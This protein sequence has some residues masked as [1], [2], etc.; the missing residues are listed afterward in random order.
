MSTENSG[1]GDKKIP[2]AVTLYLY[3]VTFFRRL[4]G[5]VVGGTIG[6]VLGV[7]YF[8]T[9]LTCLTALAA[10]LGIFLYNCLSAEPLWY[11]FVLCSAAS[12]AALIAWVGTLIVGKSLGVPAKDSCDS[13]YCKGR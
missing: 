2:Q 4:I 13:D 12:T 3:E 9:G 5:T 10:C 7:V 1:T 11:Y 6:I 8:L